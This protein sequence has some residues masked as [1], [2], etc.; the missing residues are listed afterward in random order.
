MTSVGLR[1][2]TST[3]LR[4]GLG[5]TLTESGPGAACLAPT[6]RRRG[7]HLRYSFVEDEEGVAVFALVEFIEV[8]EIQLFVFLGVHLGDDPGVDH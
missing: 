7:A 4:A 1:P 8:G 5:R 2:T 3:S 6:G